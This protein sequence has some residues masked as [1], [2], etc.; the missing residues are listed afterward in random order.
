[1]NDDKEPPVLIDRTLPNLRAVLDAADVVVQVLD[2]REPMASRSS[3]L[4]AVVSQKLDVK[5][6]LVL[7]KIGKLFGNQDHEKPD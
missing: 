7:N 2:A 1:L 6:L 4:E 5:S 3:H